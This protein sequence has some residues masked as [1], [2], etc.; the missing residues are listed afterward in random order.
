MGH[1]IFCPS[2]PPV[3]G[4][5]IP[6]G[7]TWFWGHGVHSTK[8]C[9]SFGAECVIC[10]TCR[11]QIYSRCHTKR[12]LLLV[13]HRQRSI[14]MFYRDAAYG[15]STQLHPIYMWPILLKLVL[16]EL[17]TE[18]LEFNLTKLRGL[19][20]HPCANYGFFCSCVNLPPLCIILFIY[21]LG[22]FNKHR[23]KPP[24]NEQRMCCSFYL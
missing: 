5:G 23:T 21:S 8:C 11:L 19:T 16:L 17:Q 20:I 12:I 6:V 1:S 10:E 7:L 15:C 18:W 2:P 3:E 24:N 9:I 14:G 4:L 13:W 22:W